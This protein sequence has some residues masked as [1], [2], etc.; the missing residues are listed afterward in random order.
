M[1]AIDNCARC[2]RMIVR[3][4]WVGHNVWQHAYPLD[5]ATRRC[6]GATPDRRQQ[7]QKGRRA[8]D[9][10][11][12]TRPT[13]EKAHMATQPTADILEGRW[14]TVR[15]LVDDKLEER[16]GLEQLEALLD[17]EL[18]AVYEWVDDDE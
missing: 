18:Q 17:E 1:K 3:V 16:M 9:R 12:D 8:T 6:S 15:I 13:P 2:G 4:W 14:L 7:G 5:P 10:V 11:P